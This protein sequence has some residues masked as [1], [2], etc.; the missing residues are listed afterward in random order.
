MIHQYILDK[1]G[2]RIGVISAAKRYDG[3]IGIG[4]SKN[5][6]NKCDDY[7]FVE[8]EGDDFNKERGISIAVNRAMNGTN[9][10]IPASFTCL[11]KLA[12]LSN[13]ALSKRVYIE[14]YFLDHFL[15]RCKKYF[16]ERQI[17]RFDVMISTSEFPVIAQY[18][19]YKW[20]YCQIP[21]SEKGPYE[22]LQEL[23][24][25]RHL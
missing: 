9:V 7:H 21:H 17:A 8:V 19:G 2:Q 12:L 18:D 3:M 4:F 10:P 5:R 13:N 11:K 15:E 20:H 14:R 24:N 6:K 23:F 16:K 25:D 22:T 1:N